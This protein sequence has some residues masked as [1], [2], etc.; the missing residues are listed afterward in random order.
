ML[1]MC[2]PWKKRLLADIEMKTTT[3]FPCLEAAK[4]FSN[5]G[6]LVPERIFQQDYRDCK[7]ITMFRVQLASRDFLFAFLVNEKVQKQLGASGCGL[8]ALAFVADL[9]HGLDPTNRSYDQA[10]IREHLIYQLP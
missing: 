3:K 7:K 10:K 5:I 4:S 6:K 8:F 2:F 9:C 1:D